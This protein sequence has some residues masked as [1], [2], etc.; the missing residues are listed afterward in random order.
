MESESRLKLH[1]TADG[2]LN[3]APVLPEPT[4]HPLRPGYPR[5]SRRNENRH[6]REVE[7]FSDLLQEFRNGITKKDS[8]VADLENN[9][10]QD[11][12]IPN[13]ETDSRI[14]VEPKVGESNSQSE[15]PNDTGED[16]SRQTRIR[17][18]PARLNDYVVYQLQSTNKKTDTVT[19]ANRLETVGGAYPI[20]LGLESANEN[21]VFTMGRNRMNTDVARAES[22][23]QSN[24]RA[25]NISNSLNMSKK[26]R[27]QSPV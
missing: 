7:N 27:I 2:E 17:R 11:V 10:P 16:N 15:V 12:G 23:S 20:E 18:P 19:T 25:V 13:V 3:K 9:L 24:S 1:I 21:P 5:Q 6:E 8:G 14:E 26:S 4:R 22:H